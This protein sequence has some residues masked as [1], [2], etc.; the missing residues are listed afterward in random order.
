MLRITALAL[1]V[2]V[3][4]AAEDLPEWKRALLPPEGTPLAARQEFTF[5]NES[6]PETLDP[7]I[8]TGVLESRLA[9][10]LFEGLLTID[11][12]TLEPRPGV[13][14]SWQSSADG[15]DWTF[16]L[17]QAT[18]SDGQ[19]LTAADFVAS[20][21]R[22]LTKA[23]ASD[24]AYQLFPIA[25]AQD[26]FDGKV[27]DFAQVGV[28]APDPRTLVVRLRQPCP[29]FLDICAFHTLMPVPM[30]LVEEHGDRWERSGTM[31]SNGPFRL[32]EWTPRS[33]IVLERNPHYWDAA[34]VKLERITALPIQDNETAYRL[35]LDGQLNWMPKIPQLKLEEVRRHPDYYVATYFGTHFYRFN[36]ASG[37]F[38]GE[39]GKLVRQAFWLALDRA[40]IANEVLRSGETATTAI[41]PPIAGYAPPQGPLTNRERARELLARAGH[42]DAKGLPTIEIL[43]NSDERHKAVAEAIAEQWRAALKVTVSLR[44]SEWKSYLADQDA[45]NFTVCRS[46]WIG[47]YGD[48]NTFYDMFVTGGGNNR[49]GWSNARYDEILRAS[50]A[51]VDPAKRLALLAQ[52]EEILADECPIMPIA[53]YVNQGLVRETVG[54]WHQNIRDHHLWQY[55]WIEE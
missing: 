49:T 1:L 42:P 29:W 10:G 14:E 45:L 27:T 41:C 55:V 53:Y 26:Y 8:M 7:A 48:P 43:F 18:W 13:A 19:P 16:R 3:A 24:Y 30:R 2:S 54:G 6:E 47:D 12:R 31:V 15:L 21:R 52:M 22:V 28:S 32:A 34:V 17:R 35:Y 46:S 40:Q 37:P 25:G 9:S 11:P 4:C 36:C 23:T 51:E 5:S 44:N 20:W 33:R 38:A 50:Q 39:K